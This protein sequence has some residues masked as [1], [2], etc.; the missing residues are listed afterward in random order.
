MKCVK[1]D[2]SKKTVVISFRILAKNHN[3]I[4]GFLKKMTIEQRTNY[5]LQESNINYIFEENK[6]IISIE[7]LNDIRIN[8]SFWKNDNL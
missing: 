4:K 8:E 6:N 1:K 7:K 5:L 2:K 3:E